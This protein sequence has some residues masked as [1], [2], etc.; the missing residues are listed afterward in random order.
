MYQFDR[1]AAG[2]GEVT[3]SRAV[4]YLMREYGRYFG[5]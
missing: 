4:N 2:G 3:A 5:F 1:I